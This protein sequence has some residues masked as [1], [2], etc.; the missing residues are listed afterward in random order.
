MVFWRHLHLKQHAFSFCGSFTNRYRGGI[1]A[2]QAIAT[3]EGCF[4]TSGSVLLPSRSLTYETAQRC[5]ELVATAKVFTKFFYTFITFPWPPLA[6]QTTA[7][8]QTGF[9][10]SLT[11]FPENL[12][13]KTGAN[14]CL[15][16]RPRGPRE[17]LESPPI[18]PQK[19]LDDPLVARFENR[20]CAHGVAVPDAFYGSVGRVRVASFIS[21]APVIILTVAF[22]NEF[23]SDS[24]H[25]IV[26]P[27]SPLEFLLE[28][29]CHLR[30]SSDLERVETVSE[31]K[32]MLRG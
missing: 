21:T 12:R 22:P 4:S 11:I 5:E 23:I 14:H 25:I 27:D 7:G 19:G 2:I 28:V 16:P 18:S 20:A 26:S 32:D 17:P 15:L 31:L 29:P 3:V 8:D 24:A 13:Q 9:L 10:V 1:L 30:I 6:V